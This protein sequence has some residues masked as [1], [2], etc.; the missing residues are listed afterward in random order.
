MRNWLLLLFSL[1]LFTDAFSQARDSYVD[2]LERW[3]AQ[4]PK[5]DSHHIVNL[6]KLS[7]RLSEQDINKSFEYYQKV[8]EHSRKLDFTFGKS[9]AEINLG[10]L[11]STSANFVVSNQAYFQAIEYAKK[12]DALRLISISLNNIGENFKSLKDWQKCREYAQ[13]A[14]EINSRIEA[15]RGVAINYELL[16]SCDLNEGLYEDARRNLDSGFRFALLADEPSI[17]SIFYNGMGKL[18]AIENDLRAS[19]N[20]F[21]SAMAYADVDN[22]LRNKYFVHMARAS[23]LR[24]LGTNK[25]IN[26]LDAAHALAHQ[27]KY[28]EGVGESAHMLSEIY[29]QEKQQ[30]SSMK[31]F[32][33]YRQAYDSIFS[34]NNKRNVIIKESDWMMKQKELE[35]QHLQEIATLQKKDIGFKNILLG[36][37]II[38]LLL[39]GV[40]AFFIYRNIKEAKNKQML[41]FERRMLNIRM[42]SLQSQM[43]P[44]F[45]FNSL[46]SIENFVMQNDKLA[47]S[48]YLNKFATLIR[49]IL[50]SSQLDTVP[51]ATDLK[52][53]ETYI[54]LE[55]LRFNNKFDVITEIDPELLNREYLV[56]PLI[57]QPYIENA[58]LHGIAPSEKMGLELRISA[59]L[60]DGYIYYIVDDNGIGRE[61]ARAYS[62]NNRSK[63][64]SL[65]MKLTQ[66]KMK[67]YSRQ[68]NSETD[69]QVIDLFEDE[70]PAGTRIV[71]RI[72]I[73]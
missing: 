51:F 53:T 40:I 73:H 56:P 48:Q 16:S 25:I 30:D 23:H 18:A 9:L 19:Q 3:I 6:H 11:L 42:E 39:T 1:S 67:I 21:D 47:A 22:N 31:Y 12:A 27:I 72:Q 58:I 33:V 4:N 29:G 62:A 49:T 37:T 26:E 60:K 45:I 5:I 50:E 61:L 54:D 28:V 57:I 55:R 17:L 14:I 43:N 64:V 68:N 24:T 70:Q 7:Y 36:A 71:L 34:E 13:K 15:W 65:G 8:S 52:A 59:Y 63:H 41:N 35:N 46:N 32:L 2:S 69:I 10:I 44:H 38:L 66:E 20:Y